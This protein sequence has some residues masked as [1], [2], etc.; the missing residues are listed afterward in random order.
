MKIVHRA[1]P[2]WGIG[3]ILQVLE[4]GRFLAV[5][6][7]GRQGPPCHVSA[8]DPSVVR[9]RYG[10][11]EEVVL[12]DGQPAF[13]IELQESSISPLYR[14]AIE[15]ADGRREVVSE[16]ELVPRPPRPARWRSSPAAAV[17][18][19]PASPSAIARCASTSSDAPMRLAPSSEAA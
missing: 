3:E 17:A 7:S 16:V 4:D 13:V 6:F 5:R 12:P 19:P 15:R 1:Q 14:Y 10:P 18:R 11:G 9:F 2:S 8:K